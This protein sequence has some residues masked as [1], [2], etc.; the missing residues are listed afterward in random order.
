MTGPTFGHHYFR[1]VTVSLACAVCLVGLGYF[2][3]MRMTAGEGLTGMLLGIG[4]SLAAS[5]L[6]AVPVCLAMT[7]S[8][9]KVPIAILLGTTVRFI[10]ILSLVAVLAL[11]GVVDRVTF[12]VWVVISYLL[13]LLVDT[14]MSVSS[15]KAGR[16]NC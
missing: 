2:P 4:S 12:I 13:M 3:T 15:L 7:Q 16:E 8:R 10:V 14:L 6:G 11:T 9:D 1:L 5:A